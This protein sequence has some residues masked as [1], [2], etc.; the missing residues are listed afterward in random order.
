[1]LN[2]RPIQLAVGMTAGVALLSLALLYG[3]PEW[4]MR[5]SYPAPLLPL[6]WTGRL[7][8][9]TRFC[10][11]TKDFRHKAGAHASAIKQKGRSTGPAFSHRW[12]GD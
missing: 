4:R 10:A 6:H 12:L 7:T 5:R 3:V 1:M 11:S 9:S 8:I 2:K